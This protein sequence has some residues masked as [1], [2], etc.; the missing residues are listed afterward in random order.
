MIYIVFDGSDRIEI[1]APS[2]KEAIQKFLAQSNIPKWYFDDN[3]S[4][5]LKKERKND[6]VRRKTKKSIFARH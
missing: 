6:L 2:R 1:D 5:K 3:C 4:I